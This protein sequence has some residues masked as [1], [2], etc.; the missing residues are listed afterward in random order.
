MRSS[1]V[2]GRNWVPR[3]SIGGIAT[4]RGQSVK[5]ALAEGKAIVASIAPAAPPAP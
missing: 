2:C 5:A 3:K 1:V 4:G